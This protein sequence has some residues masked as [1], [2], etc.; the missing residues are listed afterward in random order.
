MENINYKI[1]KFINNLGG[2][3]NII[4]NKKFINYITQ[5][6]LK[7]KWNKTI[8][9]ELLILINNNLEIKKYWLEFFREHPEFYKIKS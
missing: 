2:E 4:Y 9:N 7:K 6:V 3:N 1:K 5:I 8:V